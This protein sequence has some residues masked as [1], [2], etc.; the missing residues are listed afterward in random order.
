MDAHI[1]FHYRAVTQ[2][3]MA[4]LISYRFSTVRI[5]DEIDVLAKVR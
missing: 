1:F 2:M 5:A 3:P 4:I